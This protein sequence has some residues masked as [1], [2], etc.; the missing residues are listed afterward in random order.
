MRI[1]SDPLECENC[2]ERS[3]DDI[4]TVTDVPQLDPETYAMGPDVR[5][6]Y[7][8]AGCQNVLGIE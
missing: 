2:D 1:E 7:V 8:C 3:H 5:D 4:E 6:V